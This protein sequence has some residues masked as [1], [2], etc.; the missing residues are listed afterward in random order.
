MSELM[1]F[2]LNRQD[3]RVATRSAMN[4]LIM[5]MEYSKF[6]KTDEYVAQQHIAPI[7]Y[8]IYF[9]KNLAPDIF[10]QLI[11]DPKDVLVSWKFHITR[12]ELTSWEKKLFIAEKSIPHDFY[13]FSDKEMFSYLA[14]VYFPKLCLW[15]NNW[16]ELIKSSLNQFHLVMS[17][18]K[19][20]NRIDTWT[21]ILEQHNFYANN[22]KMLNFKESKHFRSG[23]TRQYHNYFSEEEINTML[24]IQSSHAELSKFMDND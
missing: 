15:M 3:Y 24:D 13:S 5:P 6:I 18:P 23:Q 2:N 7:D 8:N 4:S 17:L 10:I 9:L 11:R 21:K 20:L 1:R 16:I 19:I 14:K 12:K 22:F